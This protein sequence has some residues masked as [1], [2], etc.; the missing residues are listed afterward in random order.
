MGFATAPPIQS[1]AVNHFAFSVDGNYS[2]MSRADM[3]LECYDRDRLIWVVDL[4]SD[5]EKVKPFDR[6]KEVLVVSDQCVA[7][8][9]TD[10]VTLLSLTTGVQLRSIEARR[11]FGF[12][13]NEIMSTCLLPDGRLVSTFNDGSMVVF[14]VDSEDTRWT[15]LDDGPN[16]I[17]SDPRGLFIGRD[18]WRA[19]IWNPESGTIRSERRFDERLTGLAVGTFIAVRS[20]SHVFLL[21]GD[22]L[23]IVKTF[24]APVG[25]PRIAFSPDGSKLAVGGYSTVTVHSLET[26][27]TT[28]LDLPT[29]RLVGMAFSPDGRLWAG[30]STG[31]VTRFE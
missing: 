13:V 22:D 15:K 3:T 20:L 12:L 11:T 16:E 6:I 25:L 5:A 29:G 28:T 4:K 24:P 30:D 7:V 14:Q 1:H 2:L 27:M 17:H 31:E 26:D 19:G 18:S 21:S 23:S 8:T 10:R 9:L